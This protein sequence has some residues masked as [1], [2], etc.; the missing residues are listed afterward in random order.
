M[1]TWSVVR[2]PHHPE[3]WQNKQFPTFFTNR[4][5]NSQNNSI[6]SFVSFMANAYDA[7]HND[8]K[9]LVPCTPEGIFDLAALAGFVER[10]WLKVAVTVICL[11]M[12][13][14][15]RSHAFRAHIFPAAMP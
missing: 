4:N 11:T 10:L 15:L 5:T 14:N 9:L 7:C 13:Y 8:S 2:I 12:S 1:R 6:I 3:C